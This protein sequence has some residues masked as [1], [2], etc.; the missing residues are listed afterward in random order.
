[1][2][3]VHSAALLAPQSKMHHLKLTSRRLATEVQKDKKTKVAADG[4]DPL[5]LSTRE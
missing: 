2:Q 3:L 1:M 4:I 5:V